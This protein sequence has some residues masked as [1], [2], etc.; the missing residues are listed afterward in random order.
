MREAVL[1]LLALDQHGASFQCFAP[2]ADQHYVLDH[3]SG[4]VEEGERRNILAE[5]SRIARRG[6]CL[7]L[8][9]ADP[10]AFDAL[11]LP[12]G[13]GVAKN[14][15]AYAF[16]GAKAA[17][18]PD[19][20]AFLRAFFEARKPVGAICIA[21]ALVALVLAGMGRSAALTLGRDGAEAAD[22]AALGMRFQAVASPREIVVDPEA[23]LATTAAYMFGEARLSEVWIGIDRCVEAVLRMI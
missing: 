11:L 5:S 14:L 10:A 22:M 23:R 12:G 16:D 17:V 21:P 6:Q 13:S 9:G 8:A 7:D 3:A 1:T 20:A 4:R 18:R 15:C 19:V 2:D